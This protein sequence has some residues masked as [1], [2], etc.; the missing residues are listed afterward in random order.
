MTYKTDRRMRQQLR[1]A[2][3]DLSGATEAHKRQRA[4]RRA[5]TAA[6]RLIEL[7]G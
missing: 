3:R 6:L 5:L 4:A 1:C 7:E 2:R